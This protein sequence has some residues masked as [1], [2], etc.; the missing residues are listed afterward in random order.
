VVTIKGGK[1][2]LVSL[3]AGVGI[4]ILWAVSCGDRMTCVAV[5]AARADGGPFRPLSVRIVAG[6]ST[7]MTSPALPAGSIDGFLN[8]VSCLSDGVCMA[9]GGQTRQSATLPLAEILNTRGRWSDTGAA[10]PAGAGL[11][12]ELLGVFCGRGECVAVGAAGTARRPA[13]LFAPLV[14]TYDGATWWLTP[15]GGPAEM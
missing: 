9:V 5:G 6:R 2:R 12:G 8:G 3:P 4:S 11:A 10:P 13:S 7:P 15:T 1:V 14:E